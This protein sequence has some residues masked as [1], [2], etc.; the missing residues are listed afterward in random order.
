MPDNGLPLCCFG[1]GGHGRVVASQWRARRREKVVFADQAVV[2]GSVVDDTEVRFPGLASIQGYSL[3][4][5]IG[6]NAQRA[7]LQT[8]AQQLGLDLATFVA[9][10]DGYFAKPPEAGSMVLAGAIV[11]IGARIGQGV[12]VN[13]GAI[14]EHDCTVGAFTHL[15]PGA[16]I[17]GGCTLGE[18]VWV[19]TGATLIPEL[20]IAPG[21]V[22]GAG[23]SVLSSISEPGV[24]AGVPAR[25]IR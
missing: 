19:G 15:S 8:E 4:V 21:T 3:L 20:V 22:I 7:A 24:Y 14:V 16:R 9:D 13:S 25:R 12:I 1:A 6:D 2:L 10:E 17:A 23:A 11:N 5:T 18:R